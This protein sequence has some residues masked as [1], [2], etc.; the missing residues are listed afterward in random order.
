M[1][2]EAIFTL[3]LA[4]AA[5]AIKPGAGMMMV[6][7]R[8]ITSGWSACFAFVIGFCIISVLFLAIVVFGYQFIGVDLVFISIFIKSFAAVYLIWLGFKGL[9]TANAPLHLQESKAKSFYDNLTASLFLTLSNPLTIVF[10]AGILPTIMNVNDITWGVFT[11]MA[12][13][14][15]LV[16]LI[17][18]V[19]YSAPL[20]LFRRKFKPEHLNGLKIFSSIVI[21]LVGLY[22]GYTAIP[23]KDLLSVF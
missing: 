6:M 7:S 9:Q 18:A 1:T 17:V 2:I 5:L 12:M 4:V 19:A 20:I 22:I 16:E 3:A 15:C 10:Y 14:I 23:A 8:S 21:I 11:L 13:V